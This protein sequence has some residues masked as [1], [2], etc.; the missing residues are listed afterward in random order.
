MNKVANFFEMFNFVNINDECK[1][2]FSNA[3]IEDVKMYNSEKRLEVGLCLDNIVNSK[4]IYDIERQILNGMEGIDKVKVNIRYTMQEKDLNK[5]VCQYWENIL[6][7]IE[8]Q[9]PLCKTILVDS[10]CDVKDDRLVIR[11]HKNSIDYLKKHKLEDKIK[12]T[13][14]K[15]W[16]VNTNVTFDEL[17][18]SEK[19]ESEYHIESEKERDKI[20]QQATTKVI[21][22]SKMDK[23][24]D[25]KETVKTEESNIILGKEIK[26]ESMNMSDITSEMLD[27]CVKGEII[28]VESREIKEDLMLVAFD[29]TD[30]TNSITAKIFIKKKQYEEVKDRIIEGAWI[31][32]KG[33]HQF[34]TFARETVL[35]AKHIIKAEAPKKKIDEAEVKRVE[36][37][38]HTQMSEMD[39]IASAEDVVKRAIAWGHKAVAITDHGVTQGF[40]IAMHAAEGKDIKV[41]YGLEAYIVDDLKKIVQNSKK[42]ENMDSTFVVFDIET[43]G[44][45]AQKDKITEIG[46][47]KIKEGNIIDKYST[48]VD[49]EIHIPEFITKL[50][51]ITDDMVAGC[52]KIEDI[53][54]EFLDFAGDAVLVA[55]NASFDMG[56]IKFNALKQKINIDNTVLDTVSLAR[57]ILPNLKNHKLNTLVE[58]LGI[59][60]ENHHRAVDDANATA[61]MFIKFT[62]ILKDKK[63]NKLDDI[64]GLIGDLDPK[65]LPT[66]HA[67]IL[68]KNRQGIVGINKLVSISHVKYYKKRPRIPKSEIINYR[69]DL[70]LGSACEAGEVFKSVVMD[71][72]QQEIKRLVEFYDYLEIQ[73]IGNNKFMIDSDKYPNVNSNEDL[74]KLNKKII[75]LGEKYKKPVVATCDVHFL[76]AEDEIYRRIIMK[77]KGFSDADNQPPLYFRTTNEMLTEFDYLGQEKAYE[78]VVTNTNK[79]AD[80]VEKAVPIDEKDKATPIIEGADEELRK[81]CYDKAMGIYGENLPEIVKAR[82]ERELGSIIGNGYAVLYIIA[83]KLVQ[84]SM[85]DGYLVGSRGSVGSSFAATMGGITEVNPL[86]AHYICPSCKFSDFDS[87][88]VK[89]YSGNSGC[90]MP[91]RKC[92][93][94]GEEL[95]KEGHDIPFEVF[96][97]FDGDKEPDIDLNF[98]GDYQS[99]A[100]EQT[101]QMFGKG[102]AYRAGTIG[103]LADKTAY[104]Y[105]FKYYE[106]KGIILRKAESNRLVKGCIGIKR[107]T[108][109]HPG[110][111]VVLPS[112]REIYDFSPIQWPANDETASLE[113]THYDYHSIDKN[114][115]KLDILGHD[116]PTMI[117]KLEDLTGLDALKIPLDDKKVLSLWENTLALDI[118]PED[119]DGCKLGTLGVPEF[120]TDFLI[121][122]LLETKPKS[123]SDLVRVSGLTHGTD[124]WLGNAQ[125]VIQEGKGKISDV[126]STRD[127]IMTFLIN[128]GLDK[129]LSFVIMEAVRKGKGL[130]PEWEEEM[131]K[132]DLPDWYAWSCKT[133]KYMFPKAHAVAYVTMAFRVAYFKVYHPEAY[134]TSY[135]GIRASD[136]DYELMCMGREKLDKHIKEYIAKGNNA[137]KKEKDTLK[138]MK[139]VQEMYARGLKFAP[140]DLYTAKAKEFQKFDEGI[141]PSFL[142]IQGLGDAVAINIENARSDGEFTSIENFVGRTKANKTVVEILK[143]NGILKGLPETSQLCLF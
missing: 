17:E 5:L 81:M 75:E 74:Q 133:I 38:L 85:S 111:I 77:G 94:C 3:F 109:Q 118:M 8:K 23:A 9:S 28:Q 14:N 65:T 130:K 129:K 31:K 84:K 122:V 107:T 20:M 121:Q 56:F 136:F 55:H 30:K 16:G 87:D 92:P 27:I 106:E 124:V 97:G 143:Q 6:H 7:G 36:L 103:T 12:N 113:T 51:S 88:E 33:I 89:K 101:E 58:H 15:S 90:D 104:G 82:L 25:N 42:S 64:N 78:V 2:I 10:K 34:D 66:Y 108:G 138:D 59:K 32:V 41:I 37:H 139:I 126:I 21:K 134:Y 102:H 135:F 54:S 53:L 80:M 131:K 83:Q 18:L 79:I 96:M 11:V 19:E 142:A 127:D 39:A 1:G 137:T 91:D 70:I 26:E 62:E 13:I 117:R 99:K 35:M 60:L 110:G 140:I 43:T 68:A 76:N 98:S 119:I 93:K 141:M 116:D 125:K 61:A 73:P 52:P 100:H 95:I 128:R 71:A 22:E 46:A 29:I 86:S 44:L 105:I 112:N 123:F 72:N 57:A 50:T 47:V 115:L 132:I 69:E 49:P 48:F 40:P 120:G 63:I 45:N 114:L 24:Q 67:I 4:V